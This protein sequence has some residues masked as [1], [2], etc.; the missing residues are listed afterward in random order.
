MKKI[1]KYSLGQLNSVRDSQH[2]VV[3]SV[4]VGARPLC[5]GMHSGICC[6]WAEVEPEA[7]EINVTFFSVGTGHGVVPG[8]NTYL[9]TVIDGDY[10]WHVY[11]NLTY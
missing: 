11:H 6:V 7:P 1:W 5:V 3:V 10:V 2:K 9:G 4:K 8:R